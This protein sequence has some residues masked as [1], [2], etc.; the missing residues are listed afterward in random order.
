MLS[1]PEA[2]SQKFFGGGGNR[3]DPT[4]VYTDVITFVNADQWAKT[5]QGGLKPL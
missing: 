5:G 3:G 4:T 2:K 1:E